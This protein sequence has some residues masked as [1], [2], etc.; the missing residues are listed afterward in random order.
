VGDAIS[1]EIAVGAFAIIRTN[2]A[3]F[4]S[5]SRVVK[6]G[7]STISLEG[8]KIIFLRDE[9]IDGNISRTIV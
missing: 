3:K 4:K 8:V 9:T 1:L 5:S 7:F 2:A 6:F